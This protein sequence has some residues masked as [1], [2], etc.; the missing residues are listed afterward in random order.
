MAARV[1]ATALAVTAALVLAS[2]AQAEPVLRSDGVADGAVVATS[3]AVALLASRR[4][5]HPPAELGSA[6]LS[7]DRAAEDNLSARAASLSDLSL[8]TL[9]V[10]PV[11]G[12]LGA[13]GGA[14]A[15]RRGLVYGETLAVNLAANSAAKYL[16]QRP[17]PYARSHTAAA[18]GYAASQGD[19][20]YLS[21]Y[22]GHA[23]T[24]FAA[25]VA[26]SL[27]FAGHEARSDR[28]AAMWSVELGLAAA[29]SGL[30]VRAGKHYPSDVVIGA[31]IGAAIGLAVPLAHGAGY[32]PSGGEVAAMGLGLAGGVALGHFVPVG[33]GVRVGDGGLAMHLS[34][35]LLDGGGGLALVGA[36]QRRAASRRGS[37][38]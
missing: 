20:A 2:T 27:L 17:R 22:S 1:R 11:A 14:D 31:A 15:A 24:G 26:G 13:G 18:R 19:D 6:R 34:P 7:I 28:R 25:A 29:T 32:R 4:A 5:V 8:A 30:R 35:L 23:S 21:F 38:R 16:V 33:R 3:L 12:E 9:V 37:P 36:R 10:V